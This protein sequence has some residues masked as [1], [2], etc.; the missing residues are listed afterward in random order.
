[1]LERH[2]LTLF[3][4]LLERSS[5]QNEVFARLYVIA[6]LLFEK[7]E[8]A[9][10][11]RELFIGFLDEMID[12]AFVVS[13]NLTETRDRRHAK[14][15]RQS[16]VLD[17]E[18]EF[19]RQVG[20]RDSVSV[21]N[22]KVFEVGRGFHAIVSDRQAPARHRFETRID[23]ANAP[24]FVTDAVAFVSRRL[25]IVFPVI[26]A[27]VVLTKLIRQEVVLDLPGLVARANHEV[28]EAERMVP[29]HDVNQD[30][31]IADLD[32]GLGSER[33]FLGNPRSQTS[34]QN[35]D[36]YIRDV[37]HGYPWMMSQ[38]RPDKQFSF[39]ADL[40]LLVGLE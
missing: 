1:M 19:F 40:Q 5:L 11:E 17:V 7:E 32:H 26:E 22:R 33:G 31:R 20:V 28:V 18:I 2:E 34:G 21:R 30:G 4:E 36:W 3:R 8:T 25:L 24:L 10:D 14:H 37:V 23:H 13:I 39:D 29:A 16:P 12:H 27:E 38:R 15:G 6:E 35:K 9:V